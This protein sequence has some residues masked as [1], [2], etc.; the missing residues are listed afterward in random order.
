MVNKGGASFTEYFLSNLRVN[1]QQLKTSP[2]S[3]VGL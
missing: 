2:F 1:N 3:E